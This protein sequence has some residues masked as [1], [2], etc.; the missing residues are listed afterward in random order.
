MI[1][2]I[3][4]LELNKNIQEK[5]NNSFPESIWVVAEISE[6]NV[7]RNGHCYLELIEKDAVNENIIAKTRATIWAFTYRMLKPY[8]ENAAKHE[9]S[10]GLKVLIHVNIEFH[11]LY[12]LSLNITDIDP[13][14]TVGDLAQKK[15]QTIR[16]LESEG[17]INMNKEL[18]FPVVPQ[19]IAVISSETAAG[20]QD[21]INQL[22][23][24]YNGYKFYT[25]LFPTIMQG[26][27]A[28]ESIIKSLERIYENENHFD[29]VVII[30]GGGS[31]SDLQCFNNYL[32]ASNIAQFPLPIITGIGHDKDESVVDIVAHKKLK[33]P[34]AA[35]EYIIEKV[36]LYEE[37][38][39]LF[40]EQIKDISAGIIN[41]QKT[42]F[43]GISKLMLPSVK[44]I[45]EKYNNH[46]DRYKDQCT[47]N[48]NKLTTRSYVKLTQYVKLFENK[49]QK[50]FNSKLNKISKLEYNLSYKALFLI[51]RNKLLLDKLNNTAELVNPENILKRGF[52][53]TWL[54]GKRISNTNNI[55]KNDIII[56]KLSSGFIRSTV[57]EKSKILKDILKN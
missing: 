46:L 21:F 56:T 33:T 15:A 23:N 16:E 34:T 9:L 44:I 11:E 1:Q 7:N 35:A 8:F 30:R 28:E 37:N 20:Y 51:Q 39:F 13:N 3:T 6:I 48:I 50:N 47:N 57:K 12:G 45:L 27:Q 29:L 55:N 18:P 10:Q 19:K 17:V 25:K 52:S 43:I 42:K 40:E 32:L 41:D 2:K 36:S 38:L 49:L 53:L 14:Y 54:H 5:L 4:L 31:Q 26:M 22:T 24:N